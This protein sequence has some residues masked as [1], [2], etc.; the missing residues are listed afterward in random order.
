[1]ATTPTFASTNIRTN[2]FL[3]LGPFGSPYVGNWQDQPTVALPNLV[4]AGSNG[5]RI[6]EVNAKVIGNVGNMTIKFYLF[7]GSTY[8]L[9]DEQFLNGSITAAG[10]VD[11][12]VTYDYLYIPSGW[13]FRMGINGGTNEPAR[14][15]VTSLDL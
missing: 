6:T 4:T 2:T 14:I 7:D 8:Y 10:S 5:T 15:V 11:F 9:F 12:N 13:S 3:A 1:M